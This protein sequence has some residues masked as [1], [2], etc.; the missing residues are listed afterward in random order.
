[1]NTN[2]N[3]SDNENNMREDKLI[4][5][6]VKILKKDYGYSSNQIGRG[7]F[8]GDDNEKRADIV[9]FD[10]N[11]TPKIVVE[12]KK[13]VLLLPLFEHQ[14]FEYVKESKADY[15]VLY[16]GKE[17]KVFQ[18]QGK[19]L[20][21]IKNIPKKEFLDKIEKILRKIKPLTADDVQIYRLA[22]IVRGDFYEYTPLLQILALKILD[23]TELEGKLFHDDKKSKEEKIEELFEV[24]KIHFSGLFASQKISEE[25]RFKIKFYELYDIVKEYSLLKSNK[26]SISKI[27]LKLFLRK[28]WANFPKELSNF[29]FDLIEPEKNKRI[30]IPYARQG[31]ILDLPEILEKKFKI[32]KEESKNYFLKNFVGVEQNTSICNLLEV[33]FKLYQREISIQNTDFLSLDSEFVDGFDYIISFPPISVYVTQKDELEG[34]FGDQGRSQIAYVVKQL[35]KTKNISKV[36]LLLPP[37]FL[38]AENL[39]GV[40]LSLA[41]PGHLRGIIQ[42]PQGIISPQ[43]GIPMSIVIL[44]FKRKEGIKNWNRV[45]LSEFPEDKFNDKKLNSLVLKKIKNDFK[46][47]QNGKQFSESSVSFHVHQNDLIKSWSVSDKIP[48]LQKITNMSNGIELSK[49]GNIWFGKPAPISSESEKKGRLISYLRIQDLQDGFI[50]DSISRKIRIFNLGL[51][52]SFLIQENDILVSCQGTVGKIAIAR[53]KDAGIMPSPQI[54]VIRPNSKKVLPEFLVLS[55]NSNDVLEQLRIKS[56]G[57]FFA[58]I[59]LESLKSL[60]VPIPPLS[61]Q[62][63]K[64]LEFNKKLQRIETLEKE[65]QEAKKNIFKSSNEE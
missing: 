7:V 37:S 58:R 53:K 57:H 30:L 14:L 34:K 54:A 24:G 60:I 64:L 51:Y 2:K 39:N 8:V 40:R 28:D 17:T 21:P 65:L 29:M 42:L 62:K 3:N 11:K 25:R 31:P 6:F 38:S 46:K 19:N 49:I 43:S 55:L 50:N 1:M 33:I 9:I 52:S 56:K 44:D 36:A 45:F 23:E 5:D 47:F 12:V 63:K 59:N 48:E 20:V 41:H 13:D 26:E 61:E 18:L 15:G 4:D 22:D 10:K 16:N 35:Q 27:L 32:N